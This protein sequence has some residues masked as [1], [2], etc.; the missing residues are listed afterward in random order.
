MTNREVIATALIR[1]AGVHL[2]AAHDSADGVLDDLRE[3]GLVILPT[4][5]STRLRHEA[6]KGTTG[7]TA[8]TF[9]TLWRNLV[10]YARTLDR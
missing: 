5:S 6:V 7:I 10:T 8:G 2:D 1:H 3:A 9:S 4:A